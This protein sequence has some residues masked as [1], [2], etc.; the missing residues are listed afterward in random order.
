MQILITTTRAINSAKVLTKILLIKRSGHLPSHHQSKEALKCGLMI[1]V[2]LLC[3]DISTQTIKTPTLAKYHWKPA[4]DDCYEV[5]A[6][7]WPSKDSDCDLQS[8]DWIQ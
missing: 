2:M 6:G 3:L 5:M 7:L 1:C 8:I 4:L